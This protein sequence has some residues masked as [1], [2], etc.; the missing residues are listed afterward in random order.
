MKGK[1]LLGVVVSVVVMGA[2]LAGTVLAAGPGVG[3]R[4]GM[5]SSLPVLSELLAM[6]ENELWDAR[7]DGKTF[8]QI[9]AEKGVT[10]QQMIDAVVAARKEVVDQALK[11]GDITQ[12]QADWMLERAQS[13]AKSQITDPFPMVGPGMMGRNGWDD[14]NRFGR[15]DSE[16]R[17]G[18]GM[19]MMGRGMGMMGRGMGMM[20]RGMMGDNGWECPLGSQDCPWFDQADKPAAT[21]SGSTGA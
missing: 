10:E 4:G 21:P 6:T 14:D 2:V 20:G 15:G 5:M 17:F 13:A 9:G 19:G 8:A 7:Q 3:P 16:G 12:A 1:V 11:D 18:R